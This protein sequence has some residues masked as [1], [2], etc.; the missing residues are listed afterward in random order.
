MTTTSTSREGKGEVLS[1]SSLKQSLLTP[2]YCK[3]HS[4]DWRNIFL[5]TVMM[6]PFINKMLRR[7]SSN[8]SLQTVY[9]NLLNGNI[10]QVSTTH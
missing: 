1:A 5:V 3:N 10:R 8:S 7:L 6:I 2:R 9:L 4:L